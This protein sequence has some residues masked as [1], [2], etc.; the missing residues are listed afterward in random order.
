MRCVKI[1][2]KRRVKKWGKSTKIWG[3][4]KLKYIKL[5]TR[6]W[7]TLI[8]V[9]HVNVTLGGAA[10]T[11]FMIKK[12][13]TPVSYVILVPYEGFQSIL[14][15]KSTFFLKSWHLAS[16]LFSI[17]LLGLNKNCWEPPPMSYIKSCFLTCT[18][19]IWTLFYVLP[20]QNLK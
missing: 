18:L 7:Q 10:M 1:S 14:F 20:L 2:N 8:W 3:N 15:F 16:W 5:E 19:E 9:P 12:L 6:F 4:F 17:H 13:Y 11:T